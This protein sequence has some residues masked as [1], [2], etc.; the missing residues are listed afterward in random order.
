MAGLNVY[1]VERDEKN[2]SANPSTYIR[3]GLGRGA[4]LGLGCAISEKY[5]SVF[6]TLNYFFTLN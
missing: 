4:G 2:V 1:R 6:M 3:F 5:F